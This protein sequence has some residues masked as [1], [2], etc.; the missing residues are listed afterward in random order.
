MAMAVGR[1]YDHVIVAIGYAGTHQLMA[2]LEHPGLQALAAGAAVLGQH[3]LLDL[4]VGGGKDQVAVL[5]ELLPR[6]EA[7]DL[8]LGFKLGEEIHDGGAP[9]M[10][11]GLGEPVG[12]KPKEA[13]EEAKQA[14]RD[15]EDEKKEAGAKA[16]GSVRDDIRWAL[17]WP[18]RRV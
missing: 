12:W 4:A 6:D 15:A 8:L 16:Q 18:R 11:T 5:G 7:E 1:G 3:G 13:A 2:L 14:K 17:R 9:G 10:A